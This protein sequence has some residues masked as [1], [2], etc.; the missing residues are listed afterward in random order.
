[1]K[2]N[3][4]KWMV[5]IA[6]LLLGA[7]IHAQRQDCYVIRADNQ[8][9]RAREITADANGNLSVNVDGNLKMPLRWG[10][11]R[12]AM[13]P[14]PKEV[15]ELEKLFDADNFDEVIKTAPA[16]FDQYKYL[17]WADTIAALQCE[18]FLA[19]G[20][21]GEASAIFQNA[22]KFPAENMQKFQRVLLLEMLAKKEFD[23]VENEL[24]RMILDKDDSKAAFAFNMKGQL[25]EAKGQKREA[26][27]EYLKTVILFEGKGKLKRERDVAKQKAVAL[28]KELKDPRV[29]K[30]EALK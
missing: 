9:I 1:M 3:K 24:K 28:M 22:R 20:K 17:G 8:R 23:R 26:I 5:A 21:P 25:Y 15:E 14:K 27:L 30:I 19:L 11:Y 16:I 7:I 13:I 29:A 2:H 12:L 18:S 10:S 4:T 6:A